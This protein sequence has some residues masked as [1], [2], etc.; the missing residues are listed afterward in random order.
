MLFVHRRGSAFPFARHA[1]RA[2][3]EQPAL[4]LAALASPSG[5]F[6]WAPCDELRAGAAALADK[7]RFQAF[8]FDSVH[9]YLETLRA[10]A[11][12]LVLERCVCVCVKGGARSSLSLFPSKFL[13]VSFS[14]HPIQAL[15]VSRGATDRRAR[16]GSPLSRRP[17]PPL[18]P[19]LPLSPSLS[20][21]LRARVAHPRFSRER[22][23][24]R[25]GGVRGRRLG[26]LPQERAG[27]QDPVTRWAVGT[28]ARPGPQDA[29][30][31]QAAL[32]HAV[33]RRRLQARD[34]PRPVFGTLRLFKK[35]SKDSSLSLSLSLEFS[36]S[37][38]SGSPPKRKPRS[39]PTTSTASSRTCS[40]L[41]RPQ[42]PAGSLEIVPNLSPVGEV[43]IA[44]H[45]AIW[46]SPLSA[47]G[48]SYKTRASLFVRGCAPRPL[49]GPEPAQLDAQLADAIAQVAP[50]ARRPPK[51]STTQ[52]N[53]HFP[54]ARA[55]ERE[56]KKRSKK[57]GTRST[58]SD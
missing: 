39:R 15:R 32:G 10:R 50:R 37:G 19:S 53:F 45:I 1:Q 3:A 34:R 27:A 35:S 57:N 23:R 40:S 25:P 33:R 11:A 6:S 31:H 41:P 20:L 28:A 5:E 14:T 30:A 22:E 47:S 55:R 9:E 43:E 12:R 36:F 49:E 29:R 48:R 58:L 38:L 21:S 8:P 13:L 16:D 17:A 26:L 54:A 2:L 7:D 51:L 24:E 56:R 18:F 4:A 44:E 42:R 52:R 46:K